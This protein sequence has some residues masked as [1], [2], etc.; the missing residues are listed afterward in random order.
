VAVA[1]A[2]DLKASGVF[3]MGIGLGS[4]GILTELNQLTSPGMAFSH[5]DFDQILDAQERIKEEF[6][7][8]ISKAICRGKRA[9][10]VV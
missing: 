2:N 6:I 3:V 1:A 10:E 8:N 5:P 4:S 7:Y 9:F